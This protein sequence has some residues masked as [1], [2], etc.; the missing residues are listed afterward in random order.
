MPGWLGI[1][2]LAPARSGEGGRGGWIANTALPCSW[3]REKGCPG[4]CLSLSSIPPQGRDATRP[5]DFHRD[6]APT[7]PRSPPPRSGRNA[8]AGPGGDGVTETYLFCFFHHN[9]AGEERGGRGGGGGA[10]SRQVC[11]IART[12]RLK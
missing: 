2:E 1:G 4:G 9:F 6:E 7:W 5:G 11:L 12:G 3:L 10:S 8:S